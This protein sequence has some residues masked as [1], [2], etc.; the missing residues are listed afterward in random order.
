MRRRKAL[1]VAFAH[2]GLQPTSK[3]SD[4]KLTSR[5]GEE[6]DTPSRSWATRVHQRRKTLDRE[7]TRRPE[8]GLPG[9]PMDPGGKAGAA[10][11]GT[12]RQVREKKGTISGPGNNARGTLEEMGLTETPRVIAGDC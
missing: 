10:S 8:T 9:N 4:K 7:G 2:E 6:K 12:S 5:T 3:A 1:G 11:F